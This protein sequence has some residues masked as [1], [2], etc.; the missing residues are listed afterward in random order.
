M[1]SSS[2]EGL[3]LAVLRNL[4]TP[5]APSLWRKDAG[6]AANGWLVCRAKELPANLLP[7]PFP[8]PGRG[9][10]A[11]PT[12]MWTPESQRPAAPWNHCPPYCLLFIPIIFM[13]SGLSGLPGWFVASGYRRRDT[14][15]PSGRLQSPQL[16]A[17]SQK[18][19]LD[20][21]VHMR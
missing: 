14:L 12:L 6:S 11:P 4:G 21:W 3:P 1:T 20:S 16:D 7:H 19:L 2:P 8:D 9:H 5:P 18:G 13:P 10:P 15:I 17:Y